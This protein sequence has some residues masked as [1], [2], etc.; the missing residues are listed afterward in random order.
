MQGAE[1]ETGLLGLEP[2]FIWDSNVF[3][4]NTL[5]ARPLCRSRKFDFDHNVL[6]CAI[7]VWM[8]LALRMFS[9]ITALN[10]PANP[11]SVL[12]P[13]GTHKS[14][15]SSFETF[16]HIVKILNANFSSSS[17]CFPSPL[18]L[19]CLTEIVQSIFLLAHLTKRTS[20]PCWLPVTWLQEDHIPKQQP[21]AGVVSSLLLTAELITMSLL[22]HRA[23]LIYLFLQFQLQTCY[24]FLVLPGNAISPLFFYC[25]PVFQIS[26]GFSIFSHLVNLVSE[27]LEFNQISPLTVIYFIESPYKI[28]CNLSLHSPQ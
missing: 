5:S 26:T 3:N 23:W 8:C 6:L 22:H 21:A 18:L 25:F 28:P 17:L 11:C 1:W 14:R 12:I 4:A 13:P 15:V 2:A 10:W 16:G 27:F 20:S 24:L 9:T 7:Y 19:F